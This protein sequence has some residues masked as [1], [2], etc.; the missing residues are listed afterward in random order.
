MREMA[1]RNVTDGK[2]VPSNILIPVRAPSPEL[3]S[4][5][6]V[7]NGDEEAMGIAF[8]SG[9]DDGQMEDDGHGELVRV[10]VCDTA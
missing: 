2:S 6:E 7:P 10:E 9:G 5:T 1:E 4:P 8:S 3:P